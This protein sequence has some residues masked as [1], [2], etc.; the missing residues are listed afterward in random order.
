MSADRA[1]R[2]ATDTGAGSVCLNCGTPLAGAWCHACG[3]EGGPPHRSL[4][5]LGTELVETLTHADSRFWRSMR[6]LVLDPARLT[7]DYLAGR[8][9]REIPPLRLFLV[10]LFLLFG[11]GSL[12]QSGVH[13]GA[14][15]ADAH[16]K[17]VTA[18]QSLT[19]AGHPRLTHWLRDHATGALDHPNEVLAVM[20][21][22]AERFTFLMLPIAGGLLWV[23]YLPQRTHSLYDHMIFAIHSLC[24]T[25]LVLVAIMLTGTLVGDYAAWL[26]LLPVVHLF[27]HMRGVY[28]SGVAGTLTRMALLGMG[29]LMAIALLAIAL[30]AV[31][32]QLGTGT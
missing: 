20:R 16:Q 1:L 24:F 7:N 14:I 9:A 8:R 12:T 5:H 27:R 15:P 28:G 23:L 11:I 6:G 19:A 25:I 10:M 22:W 30:T 2:P 32:L 3:Q 18:I 4:L 21:E 17:A 31:G 13:V 29:S 26:V